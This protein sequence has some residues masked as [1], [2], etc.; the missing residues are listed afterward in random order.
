M[1][2]AV[3]SL[4][5][6]LA[7]DFAADQRR[8]AMELLPARQALA[9]LF[10]V[11]D[12]AGAEQRLL[13]AVPED[14]RTAAHCLQIGD[15]FAGLDPAFSRRMH[16]RA[17][18]LAPDERAVQVEWAIELQRAGF[19]AQA[20]A[21]YAAVRSPELDPRLGALHA[22]CLLRLE[23][24]G[25]ALA[26][27][28]RARS[29][30]ALPKL[31]RHLGQRLAAGITRERRRLDLRAEIR[32]GALEGAEEL[33][34][35]ELVHDGSAGMEFERA[36]LER[37][38]ALLDGRLD[39]ASRRARELWT[40]ADFWRGLAERGILAPARSEPARALAAAVAELG[41]LE[42]GGEPPRNGFTLEQALPALL[43]AEIASPEELL[44]CWQHPL[45]SRL[46]AGDAAA[47]RALCALQRAAQSPALAETQELAWRGVHEA[48]AAAELLERRGARVE[49]N[50]PLLVEALAAHP[51][52]LRLCRVAREAARR[53]GQGERA[54][55][56]RE[57]Q[58]AFTPPGDAA[59]AEQGFARL[60]ELCAADEQR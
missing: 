31:V 44:A 34:F 35:L 54:A 10:A 29:S 8:A 28:E 58:A 53:T 49:P 42:A 36:E 23:R 15:I 2:P 4:A 52:S 19:L 47:G 9:E 40:V 33:V 22:L 14:K 59:A 12:L 45:A 21:V 55:L 24:D 13:E 30:R 25:E 41:W 38:R 32:A 43:D 46:E 7:P 17:Y 57:I 60:G 18:E 3:L 11:G 6:F 27:W 56:R 50:D 26:V 20:E 1:L 16:A 48:M 51:E 5:L 39:P 37:D